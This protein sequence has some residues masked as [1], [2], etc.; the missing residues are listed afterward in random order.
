PR[1]PRA[2]RDPPGRHPG[3][4]G[5]S[6]AAA[7]QRDRAGQGARA[8]G[9]ADRRGGGPPDRAGPRRA[10]LFSRG[11]H[12]AGVAVG[13]P[14]AG[15]RAHRHPRGPRRPRRLRRRRARGG[16]PPGARG[17][18]ALPRDRGPPRSPRGLP[19]EAQTG[20]PGSLTHLPTAR[21]TPQAGDLGDGAPSPL[22]EPSLGGD[23]P[24]HL[25]TP[26]VC[27]GGTPAPLRTRSS[28][29]PPVFP[30]APLRSPREGPRAHAVETSWTLASELRQ[31]LAAPMIAARR[32]TVRVGLAP[33]IGRA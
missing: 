18:R 9:A 22:S 17:V 1:P 8:A 12:R 29:A 16:A 28:P 5:D 4:W 33:E 19:R 30:C 10:P 6:A 20:L 3:R 7:A 2:R 27:A 21:R 25:W 26:L 14:P 11:A 23:F 31:P 13:A 24:R 15:R 32:G